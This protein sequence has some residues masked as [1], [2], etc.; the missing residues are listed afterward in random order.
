MDAFHE[1]ANIGNDGTKG[2]TLA[3]ANG[4]I[5]LDVIHLD[6]C[7]VRGRGRG[8]IYFGSAL[9]RVVNTKVVNRWV[10]HWLA[11]NRE[12]SG[13]CRVDWC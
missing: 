5:A 4:N 8:A 13:E 3:K 6:G 9:S 2:S 10:N 12:S 1:G 7:G 11:D